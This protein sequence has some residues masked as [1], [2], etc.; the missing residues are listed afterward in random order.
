MKT[1]LFNQYE[2]YVMFLIGA[3]AGFLSL[4]CDQLF[5][6]IF[7]PVLIALILGAT[8]RFIC[9][10]HD[11]EES[12]DAEEVKD[13][14][15]PDKLRYV[16]P[17]P[18][19]HLFKDASHMVDLSTVPKGINARDAFNHY[20]ETGEN[21]HNID[22][23]PLETDKRYPLTPDECFKPEEDPY[24]SVYGTEAQVG[25]VMCQ[26]LI[27]YDYYM[28]NDGL[29][30]KCIEKIKNTPNEEKEDEFP[31]DKPKE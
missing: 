2:M 16:D 12:E 3:V 1:K 18:K 10:L 6:K 13:Y 20:L 22:I 9:T 21:P 28:D 23:R 25:C 14:V 4:A 15:S 17:I 27:N 29:C 19:E 8:V 5:W 11:I 30:P 26:K 7:W 31:K 24:K